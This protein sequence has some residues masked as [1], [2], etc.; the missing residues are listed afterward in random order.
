MAEAVLVS[1]LPA[2][3][4]TKVSHYLSTEQQLTVAARGIAEAPFKFSFHTFV[5]N[6][7]SNL[8]YSLRHIVERWIAQ[9]IWRHNKSLED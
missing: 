9:T 2:G 1:E 6:I 5:S 4:A 7:S 3:L 8:V